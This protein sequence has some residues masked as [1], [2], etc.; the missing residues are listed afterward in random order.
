MIEILNTFDVIDLDSVY[1]EVYLPIISST[2]NNNSN[3]VLLAALYWALIY[4]FGEM[5]LESKKKLKNE[6]KRI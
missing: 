6:Y 4:C 5:L 1:T 2:S 3:A